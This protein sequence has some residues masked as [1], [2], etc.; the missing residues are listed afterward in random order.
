MRVRGK[1]LLVGV[2]AMLASS[3]AAE[4]HRYLK[5]FP[6]AKDGMLRYVIMLPHKERGE[7][8]AFRVAI[9]SGRLPIPSKRRRKDNG[10]MWAEL[11]TDNAAT[12]SGTADGKQ[13]A[14]GSLSG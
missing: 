3:A 1:L 7:D 10:R 13:V 9:E 6:P 11:V 8:D 14:A 4:E 2:L 12:L 5:A